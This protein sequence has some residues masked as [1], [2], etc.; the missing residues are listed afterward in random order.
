MTKRTVGRQEIIEALSRKGDLSAP[1]ASKVLESVLGEIASHLVS[2]GKVKISSFGTFTV[3]QKGERIGRN[4]RTK[5]E[6][7]IPPLKTISFE[8]SKFL[9]EQT[10]G[11][12]RK[13]F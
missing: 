1:K 8:A 12:T 2:Q 6:V 13:S 9:K 11:K 5:E 3:R 7:I 10:Q 4:P